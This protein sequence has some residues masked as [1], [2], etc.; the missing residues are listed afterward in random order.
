MILQ[1]LML[2]AGFAILLKASDYTVKNSIILSRQ[3]GVSQIIIGF[4]FVAIGTSVPELSIAIVSSLNGH[5]S[6]SFG[7]IIGANVA[8]LTLIFGTM[9]ILGLKIEK[10]RLIEINQAIIFTAIVS[11]FIIYSST[12]NAAFGI[13]LLIIFYAFSRSVVMEEEDI[14][15]RVHKKHDRKKIAMTAIHLVASIAAVVIGAE[16]ITNSSVQVAEFLG[17]GSTM[18]GATLLAAG[19]TIPEFSVGIM[20]LRRNDVN[21]AIGDSIGSIV[22]NITLILGIASIINPIHVD[23]TGRFA[24]MSL[25]AISGIF[26]LFASRLKLKKEHG[27][28]LII[29]YVIFLYMILSMFAV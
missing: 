2:L 12:I 4:V 25:I 15:K 14:E 29:C 19:T 8:N 26:L 20:A 9:A 16:F 22:T 10:K 27:V 18:I 3:T 1:I 28:M 17:L 5:G 7:N 24:A 13:F 21:L 23:A 11:V 6:L